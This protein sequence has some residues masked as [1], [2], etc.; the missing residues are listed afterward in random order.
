MEPITFTFM[1]LIAVIVGEENKKQDKYID[2]LH[3]EIMD[4]ESWKYRM[5][6]ELAGIAG[7]ENMNNAYQ[8]K[9]IDA[10]VRKAL[11][12]D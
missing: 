11:S 2:E 1:F 9:Q 10:L 6:T 4:L 3:T 12:E 8:Q 7:K 5:S